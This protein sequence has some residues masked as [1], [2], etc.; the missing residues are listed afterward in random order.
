M[1]FPLRFPSVLPKFFHIHF[2]SCL[3]LLVKGATSVRSM[4]S[5]CG[6]IHAANLAKWNSISV[7]RDL[8]DSW[9]LLDDV[10]EYICLRGED[11]C[12]DWSGSLEKVTPAVHRVSPFVS[13]TSLA[14]ASFTPV[15]ARGAPLLRSHRGLFARH[16]GLC[17]SAGIG[18]EAFPC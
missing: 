9:I 12:K 14:L 8:G 11:I 16:A 5:R 7:G 15:G 10:G 18:R 13:F 4:A 2:T 1:F 17:A 6:G 3:G